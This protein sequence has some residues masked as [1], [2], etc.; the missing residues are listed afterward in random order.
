MAQWLGTQYISPGV[1]GS[2]PGKKRGGTRF[3][4][5]GA[6]TCRLPSANFYNFFITIKDAHLYPGGAAN[7]LATRRIAD[8]AFIDFAGDGMRLI[9]NDQLIP[10]DAGYC[11]YH[12]YPCRDSSQPIEMR[13]P[14]QPRHPEAAFAILFTGVTAFG[15][16][17]AG[18]RFQTGL[19][20]LTPNELGLLHKQR[21]ALGARNI[22][23]LP[24]TTDAP[25][26]LLKVTDLPCNDH[27]SLRANMPKAHAK[28]RE[29]MRS[30]IVSFDLQGPFPP[31]K[32]GNNCYVAGFYILD[33]PRGI[34]TIHLELS[35]IHI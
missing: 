4:P 8:R 16:V 33:E 32:H 3:P 31:S 29:S 18:P 17:T 21:T 26:N 23:A 6:R 7:I 24:D 35:L 11:A 10:F 12:V 27:D 15:G 22:K 34:R 28:Q 2:S 25:N 14:I 20:S 9:S 1:A 13:T 5:P 19:H 30:K